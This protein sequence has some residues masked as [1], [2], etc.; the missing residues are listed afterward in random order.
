MTRILHFLLFRLLFRLAPTFN[1]KLEANCVFSTR[2]VSYMLKICQRKSFF[3]L[4][5]PKFM[6]D[7]SFYH[8]VS[9]HWG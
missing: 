3:W 6:M 8:G 1:W 4:V 5:V 9:A 2:L 7:D